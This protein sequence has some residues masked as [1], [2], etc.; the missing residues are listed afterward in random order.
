MPVSISRKLWTDAGIAHG[1]LGKL[2]GQLFHLDQPRAV[3]TISVD[4]VDAAILQLHE[5]WWYCGPSL[6]RSL[7]RVVSIATL[8]AGRELPG[9]VNGVRLQLPLRPDVARTVRR[10]Q[11]LALPPAVVHI[12]D[13]CTTHSI[14]LTAL[15]CTRSLQDM[16]IV[17]FNVSQH[18]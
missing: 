7:P 8:E 1:T 11:G 4:R 9:G 2:L 17:P 14:V 10:A 13:R 18:M 3:T 5:D 6:C 12:G 15:G 16:P